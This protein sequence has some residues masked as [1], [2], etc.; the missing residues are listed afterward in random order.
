[1]LD[2]GR[3]KGV[4]NRNEAEVCVACFWDGNGVVIHLLVIDQDWMR[5]NEPLLGPCL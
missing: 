1:M 4:P 3:I 2:G 5:V